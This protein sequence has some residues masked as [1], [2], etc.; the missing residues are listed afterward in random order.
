MT[1]ACDLVV[2]ACSTESRRSSHGLGSAKVIFAFVALAAGA[3]AS[4]AQLLRAGPEFRVNTET[5]GPQEFADVAIDDQGD[6]VVV[7]SGDDV[8]AQLFD[9]S[10]RRV[11]AEIAVGDGFV[12]V[13]GMDADGDFVAVW[14]ERAPGTFARGFD[15][16][17][18]ALGGAFLVAADSFYGRAVEMAAAGSFVVVWGDY[19][20]G[21]GAQRFDVQ[22]APVGDP[23]VVTEQDRNSGGWFPAIAMNA[24]GAFVVVASSWDGR[25]YDIFG[26]R[27]D[28]SGN[29]IGG[30]FQVNIYT[31]SQQNFAAAAMA[32]DGTFVVV[33][34]RSPEYRQYVNHD[35]FARRYNAAGSPVGGEI[36]VN[37]RT[38]LGSMTPMSPW[39][40]T[41]AF[42]W[43]GPALGTM[44]TGTESSVR[45]FGATDGAWEA[46]FRSTATRHSISADPLSRR[47]PPAT[48]S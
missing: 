39:A 42:M 33:W 37:T 47:I 18:R 16:S 10:G 43:C 9:R 7:W 13:V 17:G 21:V 27:F 6:F 45:A 41:A 23:I 14:K 15:R 8:W 3:G 30:A 11:G 19:Y 29:P 35:I 40:P 20:G 28:P 1:R 38:G 5:A 44:A 46:S 32:P 48:W 26:K 36:Q 34:Q 22:R 24:A 12:P 25:Q 2:T 4:R 31:P